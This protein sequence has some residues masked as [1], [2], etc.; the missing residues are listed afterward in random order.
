MEGTDDVLSTACSSGKWV[1]W[2]G[3][4]V[5][6]TITWLRKEDCTV[7]ETHAGGCHLKS[8]GICGIIGGETNVY[9]VKS[10]ISQLLVVETDMN[11]A[12]LY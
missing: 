9:F 4:L 10:F 12:D 2:G 7:C 1:G 11:V 6:D 3:H 5:S 8:H